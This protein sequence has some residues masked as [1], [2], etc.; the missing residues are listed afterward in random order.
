MSKIP[1]VEYKIS[2]RTDIYYGSE[3]VEL[4]D[5]LLQLLVAH[6]VCIVE[7]RKVIKEGIE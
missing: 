7:E 5:K 6:D 4:L 2:I 3:S 1:A